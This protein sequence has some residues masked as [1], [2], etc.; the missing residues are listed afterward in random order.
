LLYHVRIV[1]ILNSRRRVRR[2]EQL[3]HEL[4]MLQEKIQGE[5]R[6]IIF[7]HF[8]QIVS[9]WREHLEEIVPR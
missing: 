6:K 1:E 3:I 2:P 8:D 7:E 4:V 9:A 5:V